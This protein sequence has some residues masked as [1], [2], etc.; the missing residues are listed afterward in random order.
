VNALLAIPFSLYTLLMHRRRGGFTRHQ[1]VVIWGIPLRVVDRRAVQTTDGLPLRRAADQE[2][3][4]G[5]A[6]TEPLRC[7]GLRGCSSYEP[8]AQWCYDAPAVATCETRN[9][10]VHGAGA[11]G[12]VA[13]GVLSRSMGVVGERDQRCSGN[14]GERLGRTQSHTGP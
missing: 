4:P 8:G 3:K 1:L 13:S 12:C 6:T 14:T 11:R 10:A 5:S 7:L 2:Q 9:A